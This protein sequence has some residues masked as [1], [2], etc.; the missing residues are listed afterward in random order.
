MSDAAA[1]VLEDFTREVEQLRPADVEVIDAHTH[2]GVDED[3]MS[4]TSAELLAMMDVARADR[5]LTF[6]LHDPDRHPGYRV[7][8]DRVLQWAAESEGRLI[9][10][11]RLD[12]G[13][14][15]VAEAERALDA[16][17]VGIKLH[18]RAQ[19]F[20]LASHPGVEAIFAVVEERQVPMLIHTGAGL[21][22]EFGGEMV[23]IVERHPDVRLILAHLGITDQGIMGDGLAGYPSIVYDSS[24]MNAFEFLT[25]L[26]RVP[27]ERI[28]FGADPPYGRTL[29]ALYLL[30]R[31]LNCIGVP[32]DTVREVLGGSVRRM[33]AG[34]PLVE[35]R[36]PLA[37]RE[38]R[39]DARL[40]RIHT[41]C[42]MTLSA[43]IGG[44]PERAVGFI[45]LARGVTRDPDPG[46]LG[47]LFERLGPA[48]DVGAADMA[49]ATDPMSARAAIA[50]IFLT[51]AAAATE[52]PQRR[53]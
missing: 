1:R 34:E 42:M 19:A 26:S 31:S 12:P 18:P 22:P 47:P 16:G 39:I 11:A 30:L 41:M 33:L 32:E 37:P 52:L 13:E 49:K 14:N 38:L 5:A 9:P 21:P 46:A 6:P 3:G 50:P 25:L 17:A 51:M 45:R 4:L 7:P 35:A 27:A 48:L 10:F 53:D 23:Q 24:W 29:N 20:G 2:L 15:P 43:L 28:V 36:E 40:L 8:N 44:S